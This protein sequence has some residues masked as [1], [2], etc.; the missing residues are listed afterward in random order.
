MLSLT[1]IISSSS[2]DLLFDWLAFPS[3]VVALQLS[4]GYFVVK[5]RVRLKET[6]LHP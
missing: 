6:D 5:V 2:N 4:L 1:L 3:L